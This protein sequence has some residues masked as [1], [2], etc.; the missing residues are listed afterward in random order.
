VLGFYRVELSKRGWTEIDGAVV[1]PER[2]VITF[3]TTDGSALLR[4][5]H[6]EGRTIAD[7]SL[8]KPAAGRWAASILVDAGPGSIS[9]R[10]FDDGG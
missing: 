2:A 4:L 6:Q 7:L 9:V 1:A 3:T 8:H 10:E 5:I